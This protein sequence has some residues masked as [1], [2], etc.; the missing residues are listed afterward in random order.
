LI[1]GDSAGVLHEL[2]KPERSD[3]ARRNTNLFSAVVRRAPDTPPY[4]EHLIHKTLR[5]HMVRSKTELIIADKLFK[6]N[7]AYDYEKAL[8]GPVRKGR[9]FPD[10]SFSD[11]SGDLI[12]WEHFGR[13]DDPQYLKGHEWKM[14]WYADN[15]FVEGENLLVT[16]ETLTSGIDSLAFERTLETIRGLV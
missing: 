12:V 8:D 10:F 16:H 3:A 9:I 15:G 7:I 1:E 6:A 2:S 14:K 5:G 13:M 11:A 4:A